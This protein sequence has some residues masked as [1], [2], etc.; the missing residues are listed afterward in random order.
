LEEW[1]D[2]NEVKTLE[3][4]RTWKASIP[5]LQSA[6]SGILTFPGSGCT[7]CNFSHERKRNVTA[8][9]STVHGIGEDVAPLLCSV[10]RVFSSELH[11][12]WR[13]ETPVV[14]NDPTDEGL[15][16]LHQFNAEFERFEQE[17]QRSTVGIRSLCLKANRQS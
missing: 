12:F 10:Q 1:L 15:F 2:E 11:G 6:V 9:M 14:E 8:H 13:L 16:A 5:V 4:C 17:D 3:D 7:V